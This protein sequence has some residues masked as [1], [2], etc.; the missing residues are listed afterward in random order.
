MSREQIIRQSIENDVF[1]NY[2]RGDLEYEANR[3]GYPKKVEKASRSALEK[4]VIEKR[5]EKAIKNI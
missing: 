4:F 2:T 3:L 5:Y 1:L